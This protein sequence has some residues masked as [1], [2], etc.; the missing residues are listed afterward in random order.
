MMNQALAESDIDPGRYYIIPMEDIN[1]NAI[2]ASH[3]K[4]MTP[5]FSIVDSGNPLVK[6]LHIQLDAFGCVLQYTRS[7][8]IAVTR[9][10]QEQVSE[11]LE[12][13]E[14]TQV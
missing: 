5:P 12:E 7:G 3:V 11:F 8:R 13:R 1:F 9:G 4:M 10:K 6:Q 14:K 2:W